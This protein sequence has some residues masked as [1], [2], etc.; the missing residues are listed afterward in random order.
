MECGTRRYSTR[1][2]GFSLLI[3]VMGG[4]AFETRV[5]AQG[6]SGIIIGTVV[7]R[8]SGPRRLGRDR[9]G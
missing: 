9:R 5:K 1:V 3:S 7:V 4:I 8:Q 6:A 2:A